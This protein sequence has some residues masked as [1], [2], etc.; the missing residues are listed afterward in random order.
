MVTLIAPLPELGV[1]REVVDAVYPD[2]GSGEWED[3]PHI[4]IAA[5]VL[6]FSMLGVAEF[7]MRIKAGSLK[8]A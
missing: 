5:G 2:R 7:F 3:K 1:T 6:Y 8:K 4:A